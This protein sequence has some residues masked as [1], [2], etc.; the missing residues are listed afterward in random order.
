VNILAAASRDKGLPGED[1]LSW[2]MRLCGPR[3]AKPLDLFA[4]GATLFTCILGSPLD[5]LL[6]RRAVM[7]GDAYAFHVPED[8]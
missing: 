5:G 2:A 6:S 1:C 8:G 7:I 4:T 3:S